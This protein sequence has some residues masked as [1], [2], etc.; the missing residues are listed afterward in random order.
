MSPD[1]PTTVVFATRLHLGHAKTPPADAD[2][3]HTVSSFLA[4]A[5]QCGAGRAAIA[6]D[7]APKI[8]GYDL[9]AAVEAARD[10]Y[11]T[12]AERQASNADE[13]AGSTDSALICD[14]VPVTPWG[15]FVPALNALVG[16]AAALPGRAA[17]RRGRPHPVRQRRDHAGARVG[18]PAPRP[19]RRRYAGGRMCPPGTRLPRG[20]D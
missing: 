8:A 10:A 1:Q 13:S 7:P 19:R 12:E 3:R 2:L 20:D 11:Y 16:W 4:W 9:V 17:R 18:G 14:V 5:A 6:V 15:K